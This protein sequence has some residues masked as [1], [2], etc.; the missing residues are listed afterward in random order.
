MQS[1]IDKQEEIGSEDEEN[2]YTALAVIT[3]HEE[4]KDKYIRLK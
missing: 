3:Q 1:C 4:D 2:N